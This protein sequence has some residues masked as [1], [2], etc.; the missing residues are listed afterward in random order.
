MHCTHCN[1]HFD[2]DSGEVL[3]QSTNGHY[4]DS[5]QAR[6]AEVTTR[7]SPSAG[8][9]GGSECSN[10]EEDPEDIRRHFVRMPETL[11]RRTLWDDYSVVRFTMEKYYNANVIGTKRDN[12]LMNLRIQFLM[13]EITEARF[14]SA[15]YAAHKSF[16]CA[17][18]VALHLG[19]YVEYIQHYQRNSAEWNPD[20]IEGVIRE[21]NRNLDQI[22]HL[23]LQTTSISIR[24]P[25]AS[26]DTP[27]LL[28]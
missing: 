17:Q 13:N 15:I 21:I 7:T 8:G 22:A 10:N 3:T 12:T 24:L 1:T 18:A 11:I 19:V 14:R 4:R 28:R 20:E 26:A 6:A 23:F 16:E 5:I 9:A 2:W 25:S 27:A